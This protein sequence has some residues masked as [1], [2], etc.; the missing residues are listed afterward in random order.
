M[1]VYFSVF[2]FQVLSGTLAADM[3]G[4]TH[5]FKLPSGTEV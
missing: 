2:C 1:R 4:T 3:L 5:I